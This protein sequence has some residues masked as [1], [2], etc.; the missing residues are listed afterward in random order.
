[1]WLPTGRRTV[2]INTV[3]VISTAAA[4]CGGRLPGGGQMAA[5]TI[6]P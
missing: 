4:S 2:A 5:V 1:M 3:S 6:V